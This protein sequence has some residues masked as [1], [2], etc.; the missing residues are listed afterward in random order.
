MFN[1]M[2]LSSIHDRFVVWTGH[3][4]IEGGNMIVSGDISPGYINTRNQF[5]MIDSEACD[6]FHNKI[7][8]FMSFTDCCPQT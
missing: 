4:D 6:L 2:D 8:P 1:C 7:H 3:T 5:Q